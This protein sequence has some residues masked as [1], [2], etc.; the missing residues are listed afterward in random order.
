MNSGVAVGA[1]PVQHP[2]VVS[3]WNPVAGGRQHARVRRR[4]VLSVVMAL[5]AEFR[6]A[7]FQQLLVDR[8]VRF[9]AIA[10]V[11]QNGRMFPQEGTA[12]L[13]VA[14]VAILIQRGLD[15]LLGIG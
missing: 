9:V 10:A 11:L 2:I 4:P 7:D 3:S 14:T 6:L 8:A 15:Q 1:T 5:P 12:A 13:G